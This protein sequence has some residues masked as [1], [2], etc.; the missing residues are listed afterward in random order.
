M[1]FQSLT[2]EELIPNEEVIEAWGSV[3]ITR[4]R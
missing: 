4:V 3:S 2:S 1:V